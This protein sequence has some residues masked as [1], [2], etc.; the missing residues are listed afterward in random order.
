MLRTLLP[1]LMCYNCQIFPHGMNSNRYK[2][3]EN[4]HPICD[5]CKGGIHNLRSQRERVI[6]QMSTLE[7]VI[8][9]KAFIIM[10]AGKFSKI[11]NHAWCNKAIQA[12][13][14]DKLFSE[15][16]GVKHNPKFCQHRMW[17]PQKKKYVHV[18][19]KLETIHAILQQNF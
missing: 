11:N 8:N 3:L 18:D 19:Q 7:H 17:M 9:V 14:E 1:N 5:Y 13:L 4:L 10:W 15:E 12:M 2:C 6:F 16:R